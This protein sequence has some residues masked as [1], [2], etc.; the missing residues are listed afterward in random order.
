MHLHSQVLHGVSRPRA[1]LAVAAVTLAAAM[2]FGLLTERAEAAKESKSVK[3]KVMIRNLYL[4]ANLRPALDA[5]DCNQFV[6]IAGDIVNQM[7]RTDF[8]TRARALAQEIL[9]KNP[10]LVGLQEVAL[11][12]TAPTNF[13]AVTAPSATQ[14]EVDFLQLLL[15]ELNRGQERYEVVVVKDELDFESPVNDDGQGSGCGAV[16][17]NERFTQRDVILAK[18][19]KK[20]KTSNPTTG[21]FSVLLRATVAGAVPVDSIRGWTAVDAKVK[22]SKKFHFVNT[23]IEAYD[24]QASGQTGSDGNTYGK[25]AVREV[26]AQELFAPGGP[27]TGSRVILVGDFNS[28][29]DTVANN[30]DRN[31]Y[32]AILGAGFRQLDLETPPLSCCLS[33]SNLVGGSVADFD[34]QID[35]ILTNSRKIKL[36]NSSMTGHAPVDGLWPSDHAGVFTTLRVPA[37]K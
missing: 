5:E 28:D 14:V 22:G 11:W 13:G 33:D 19:G 10:D 32:L 8:P 27:A 4:G 7:R 1:L 20:V 12:R 29:D 24:D 21:T 9:S 17:H 36:V 3:A 18:V 37:K 34:H 26:Q 23:H 6:D 25:G 15:D 31:A 16:D 35:H 30:G 2:T